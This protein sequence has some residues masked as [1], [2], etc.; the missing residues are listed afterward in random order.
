MRCMSHDVARV[1]AYANASLAGALIGAFNQMSYIHCGLKD[2][3]VRVVGRLSST[4]TCT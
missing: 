4:C 2:L 1:L 3:L